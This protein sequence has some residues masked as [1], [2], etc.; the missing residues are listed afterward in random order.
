MMLPI[1]ISV[2]VAPVSYFFCASAPLVEAANRASAVAVMARRVACIKVSP[3]QNSNDRCRGP[4]P[5]AL[6][7]AHDP[8]KCEAGFRKDH[9][10]SMPGSLPFWREGD[11]KK[12]LRQG[13][14]GCFFGSQ[15]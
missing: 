8:E 1:L 12:P 14:R 11:N 9:A 5:E 2:S 4:F 6:V 13:R 10:Q 3:F 7:R 15:S